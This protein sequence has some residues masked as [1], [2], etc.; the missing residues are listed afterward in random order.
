MLVFIVS[1]SELLEK[2]NYLSRVFFSLD[3]FLDTF[4]D[5]SRGVRHGYIRVKEIVQ[6]S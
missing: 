2:Q 1:A 5:N 3:E 4:Q 6:V